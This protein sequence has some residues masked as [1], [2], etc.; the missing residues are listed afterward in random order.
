MKIAQPILLLGL[1]ADSV[2]SADDGQL[3]PPPAGKAWKLVAF[4][5]RATP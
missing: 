5:R 2:E 3:P 1:L 4:H